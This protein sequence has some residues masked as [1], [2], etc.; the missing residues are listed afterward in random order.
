MHGGR[1]GEAVG[2]DEGGV[3]APAARRLGLELG[4][5]G[6]TGSRK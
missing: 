4:D 2:E 6:S 1:V 5:A 3:G